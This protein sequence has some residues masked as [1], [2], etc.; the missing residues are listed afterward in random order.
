MACLLYT[1]VEDAFRYD[2]MV[3]L[4]ASYDANVFPP[5]EEFLLHLKAKNFQSRKVA[6]IE[7]GSWAPSA[8]KC[9]KSILETMKNITLYDPMITIRSAMKAENVAQMEEMAEGFLK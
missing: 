9:M 6:L 8:G 5:M 3:L 4:A 2:K 7:N 1:S